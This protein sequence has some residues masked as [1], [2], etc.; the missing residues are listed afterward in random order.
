MVGL[1]S[2]GVGKRGDEEQAAP[3]LAV[4]VSVSV[5]VSAWCRFGQAV[6]PGVRDLDAQGAGREGQGEASVTAP[7]A[8]VQGGVGGEFRDEE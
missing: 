2:P 4:P 7:H 5:A 1:A 3:R 8:A 6:A